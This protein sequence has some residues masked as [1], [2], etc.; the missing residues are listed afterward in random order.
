M[1]FGQDD[2]MYGMGSEGVATNPIDPGILS[3]GLLDFAYA[4][5]LA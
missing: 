3:Y 4:Q 2:R 5:G 1:V